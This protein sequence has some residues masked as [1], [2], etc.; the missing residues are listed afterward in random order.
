MMNKWL[1]IEK[2]L[3]GLLSNLAIFF[4]GITPDKIKQIYHNFFAT[5]TGLIKK[6]LALPE[7]LTGPTRKWLRLKL[8]AFVTF[9][10]AKKQSLATIGEAIKN[11]KLSGEAPLMAY[12]TVKGFWSK[13][14]AMKLAAVSPAKAVGITCSLT[15]F[16]LT[17]ISV[18]QNIQ[19]ISDKTSPKQ[20]RKIAS[21]DELEKAK[22]GRSRYRL[23]NKRTIFLRNV[24]V[25]I[26]IKNRNGMKSLLID[27]LLE[28]NNRYT[29]QYFYK[30][31]NEILI[32]DR[33]NESLQAVVPNFPLEPEGKKIIKE[34]VRYEVNKL[35][36]DLK[37]DGNVER[38]YIDSILNG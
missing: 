11:F 32:R 8:A 7:F 28:T 12:N 30:P 25:P 13:N 19:E 9:M 24:D 27:V 37:I 4:T 35:I 29:A 23:A 5:F 34:K 10:L 1:K 3:N 17:G 18:Y 15:V 26:Y 38:V 31:E 16:S 6:L 33:L 2:Y 21:A 20:E 36:E 14:V 22:W